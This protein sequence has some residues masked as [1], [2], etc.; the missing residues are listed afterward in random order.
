MPRS[1][2]PLMKRQQR[3]EHPPAKTWGKRSSHGARRTEVQ[4]R[5]E[6][7]PQFFFK[8]NVYWPCDPATAHPAFAQEKARVGPHRELHPNRWSQRPCPQG[9]RT[10]A[11]Q[12][13]ASW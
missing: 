10:G 2:P 11:D 3:M 6:I 1:A 8:F 5:W 7:V 12:T 4:P 13:S 9:P